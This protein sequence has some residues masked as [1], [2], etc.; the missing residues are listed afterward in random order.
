MHLVW[1]LLAGLEC[2]CVPVSAVHALGAHDHG[3]GALILLRVTLL[4]HAEGLHREPVLLYLHQKNDLRNMY[5]KHYKYGNLIKCIHMCFLYIQNLNP[6]YVYILRRCA[7]ASQDDSAARLH[8]KPILQ[9]QRKKSGIVNHNECVM[10]C[11]CIFCQQLECKAMLLNLQTEEQI[12]IIQ[13]Q[14]QLELQ[15][16]SDHPFMRCLHV[17]TVCSCC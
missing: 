2:R 7:D 5:I 8:C 9:L 14:T 4:P 17:R 13:P 10:V 16:K 6:K 1:R 3:C 15:T 12:V 11:S